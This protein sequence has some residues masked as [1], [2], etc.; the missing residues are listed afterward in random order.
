MSEAPVRYESASCPKHKPYNEQTDKTTSMTMTDK[1]YN[2]EAN[3]TGGTSHAYA[4][5]P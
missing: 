3:V 2:K 1:N 4:V 5:V